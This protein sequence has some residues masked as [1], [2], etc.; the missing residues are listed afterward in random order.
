MVR[1]WNAATQLLEAACQMAFALICFCIVILPLAPLFK[2]LSGREGLGWILL[3]IAIMGAFYGTVRLLLE[4]AFESLD[5]VRRRELFQTI[6]GPLRNVSAVIGIYGV[7]KLE[8]FLVH[9]AAIT[10][11]S[12]GEEAA[13]WPTLIWQFMTA[14]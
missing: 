4:P 13:T 11:S 12:N 9:G 6:L 3:T 14:L 8:Y 2:W 5:R 7:F 10:G 1:F